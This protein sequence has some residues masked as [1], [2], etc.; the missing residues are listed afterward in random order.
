VIEYLQEEYRVLKERLWDAASF[1]R[2]RTPVVSR[3][4]L[5]TIQAA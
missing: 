3:K 1:H 5:D 4:R 2:S